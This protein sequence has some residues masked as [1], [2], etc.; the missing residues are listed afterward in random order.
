MGFGEVYTAIQQGVIDGAENNELAL[1]N[2]KHGSYC[3]NIILIV[4]IDG[5]GYAGIIWK[6]LNSFSS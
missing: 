2:N 3:K 4:S 6:F 1:T 5:A